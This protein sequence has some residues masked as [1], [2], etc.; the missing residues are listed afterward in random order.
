VTKAVKAKQLSFVVENR[1]GLLADVTGALAS[2]KINI[3]AL[4]AYELDKQGVFM[5]LT[6]NNPAAKRVLA[7]Y[8]AKA[9]EEDVVLLELPDRP[10]ALQSAVD[11]IAEAGI[12]I[13]Y[14]YATAG[15]K[16]GTLC[17]MQTVDNKKAIKAVMA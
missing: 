15:K 11:S 13:L 6:D 3:T 8:G 1:V 7:K 16:T 4:V 5:M 2:R 12:D 14:V 17:V 10:G 9:V